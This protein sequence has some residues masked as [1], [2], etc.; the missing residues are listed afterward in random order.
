VSQP[1]P[2]DLEAR[3]RDL[4]GAMLKASRRSPEEDKAGLEKLF[5]KTEEEPTPDAE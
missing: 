2:N 5:A 3:L 1:D 4:S